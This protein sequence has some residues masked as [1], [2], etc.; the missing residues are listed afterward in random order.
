MHQRMM[1]ESGDEVMKNAHG[2]KAPE[3]WT[4]ASLSLD[5]RR[6]AAAKYAHDGTAT[7]QISGPH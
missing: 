6:V 4:P 7:Y 5:E 2:A 1:R 3:E